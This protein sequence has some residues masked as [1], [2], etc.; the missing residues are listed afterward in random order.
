MFQTLAGQKAFVASIPELDRVAWTWALFFALII[1]EIGTFLRSVRM[2]VF[3]SIKRPTFLDFMVVLVAE[4]L[5]M[6]GV[7]ILAFVV[8]PELDIVK[9]AML[10]NCVCVIPGILGK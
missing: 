1:P 9:A 6:I 2:C 10:T 8:F 5:H 4:T 7:G 3:K